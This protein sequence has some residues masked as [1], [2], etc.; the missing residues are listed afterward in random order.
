MKRLLEWSSIEMIN[1]EMGIR[2]LTRRAGD[3]LKG[4][5]SKIY[6]ICTW[7]GFDMRCKG[8]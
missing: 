6:R 4:Q 3:G 7:V 8:P 5:F 2:V 1:V